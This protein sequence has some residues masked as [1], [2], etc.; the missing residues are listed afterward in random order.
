MVYPQDPHLMKLGPSKADSAQA[1]CS[2]HW[3]AALSS[4][5]VESKG[6][7]KIVVSF[8]AWLPSTHQQWHNSLLRRTISNLHWDL[9][10]EEQFPSQPCAGSCGWGCG[11]SFPPPQNLG[12]QSSSPHWPEAQPNTTGLLLRPGGTEWKTVPQPEPWEP[13]SSEKHALSHWWN[14]PKRKALT[15]LRN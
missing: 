13:Q 10:D 15:C 7:G 3:R 9:L 1:L 6:D 5:G 14:C 4:I 12:R 2:W 11:W 8:T